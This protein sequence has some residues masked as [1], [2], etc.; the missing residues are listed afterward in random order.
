MSTFTQTALTGN[1]ILIEGVDRRGHAGEQV[2]FSTQWEDIKRH[3][4]YH[5][6][7][8]LVDD[9]IAALV[10]P[11]QAAVDEV[12]AV[13]AVPELDPLLYYVEHDEVEGVEST[14]AII[15]KLST[16]SIILRALEEGLEDRLIWVQG[17]LVLTA[18]PVPT[19]PLPT[20][21]DLG[22]LEFGEPEQPE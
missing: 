4:S 2:V 8:T 18:N 11:I 17:K 14:P 22:A 15:S 12:N 21:V 3:A 20:A 16:D 9:A 13:M 10:A 19:E 6:A 1:E 5:T 7:L